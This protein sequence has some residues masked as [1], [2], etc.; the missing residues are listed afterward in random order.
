MIISNFGNNFNYELEKL[1]RLF[2]PFERID[3]INEEVK[4][5]DEKRATTVTR[6]LSNS[7]FVSARVDICGR[8]VEKSAEVAECPDFQ[9]TVKLTLANCLYDCLCDIF[10]YEPSWGIL[11]GIRPARLYLKTADELGD[12]QAKKYFT[13]IL[14]VSNK[15]L[16]LLRTT[17]KSEERIISL[18]KP[19]SFSLYISIP[20]CPTRCSYCSFVSHSIDKAENIIAPYLEKLKFEIVKTGLVAKELGLDLET[21]YIGGGTPTTLSA[22]Q[23]DDLLKTVEADFDLSGIREF[24]VEAG[25]P[26][27]ITKEKL[28]VLKLHGISRIS[29]NPQ[30]LNDDVLHVIGRNHST[31]DF[32]NSMDLARKLGFDNINTDLIAGLPS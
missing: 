15:K 16:N 32:Y 31:A 3:V 7:C 8:I 28:T 30:T 29:I 26:D 2:M 20:F 6:F 27:T 1:T 17:A 10:D 22:Q 11:T 18:S 24:T 5:S 13:D 23:L 19:N 25:R 12:E 21:V 4:V 14:R 9:K